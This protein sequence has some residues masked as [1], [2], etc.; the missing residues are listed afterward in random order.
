MT[1]TSRWPDRVALA[2]VLLLALGLRLWNLDGLPRGILPD[3]A[4][5]GYDAWCLLETGADRWGDRWPL[6]LRAFGRGDYRPALYAYLTVPSIAALGINYLVIATRLPAA[7]CGIATIAVLYLA[8]RRVSGQQVA[9]WTALLLAASPWHIQFSRF[10]HES[11]LTPLFPALMLLTLARANWPLRGRADAGTECQTLSWYWM[12]AFGLVAA[13]SVYAYAAMKL[14]VPVMLLAGAVLYRRELRSMLA[15][16]TNRIALSAAAIAC[17]VTV[18]PMAWATV[19]QWDIINAR[20]ADQSLFH[21][22]WPAGKVAITIASQYAAHLGPRWLFLSGAD[23]ILST[24]PR[25]GQLNWYM[26][27]FLPIGVI[28]AWRSRRRNRAMLLAIAW[29]LL[30]PIASVL[31]E[32]GPHSL[33]AACGLGSFQWIA[34]LGVV[35]V[36]DRFGD[37]PSRRVGLT[38]A[39]ALGILLNAGWAFAQY[40]HQF[41]HRVDVPHL[42]QDDLRDAMAAIGDDWRTYDRVF[43]SDHRSHPNDPVSTGRNWQSDHPYILACLFLP[44]DPALFQGWKKEESYR[45]ATAPFHRIESMGPFTFSMQPTVLNE[46]FRQHADQRAL[47]VARPGDMDGGRVLHTIR[48]R[49]GDS[50]FHIIEVGGP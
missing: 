27:V 23:S 15:R 36:L 9:I 18:L 47:F 6:H 4:S 50:R 12:A 16:H 13:L 48:D 34:A 49:I 45:S 14:F 43:V 40:W 19:A 26:V 10:G 35:A 42:F 7:V 2:T 39:V 17:A 32:S 38:T 44:V 1:E 11:A 3:E 30:H 29:L 21:Q 31:C 8:V 25:V 20:A 46:H 28:T 37:R 5:N 24:I 33:R 41:A 22:G